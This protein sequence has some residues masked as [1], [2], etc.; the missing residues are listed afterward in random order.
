LAQLA[1]AK[2]EDYYLSD[3]SPLGVPFNSFRKASA[4]VQRANRIAACKPGS[5]CTKKFL[6]SNTEFTEIP[7]CT[8]SR[9]YQHLKIKQLQTSGLDEETLEEEMD[10]VMQKECL[11]EGLSVAPLL[12]NSIT[13]QFSNGSKAVAV[14]PGPNLAYFSGIFSL[15]QMVDHIYGRINILNSVKRANLFINELRMYVTYLQKDIDK[16][17]HSIT[18]NKTRQLKTFQQ[19]LL[20]GIVYYNELTLSMKNESEL[21]LNE[22]REQLAEIEQTVANFIIP[23][24]IKLATA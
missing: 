17:L 22:M 23:V 4:E 21:Y 6:V 9:K 13:P 19:N 24:E 18:N 15:V 7:I 10:A 16:N 11:C 5:P 3:I 20:K 12:K 8:A 1:T 14:C 2:P